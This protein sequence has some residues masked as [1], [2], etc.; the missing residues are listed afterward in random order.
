MTATVQP[1]ERGLFGRIDGVF[2]RLIKGW[3]PYHPD[4]LQDRDLELVDVQES[5]VRKRGTSLIMIAVAA[6]LLWAFTAPIN[7]GSS[8][9]GTVTVA[10]YRKAVQHPSGGVVSRVLVSEGEQVRQGQVL[11]RIN[12]LETEATVA[13]L[14]QEYINLLVSESRAKA[15]LLGRPISWDPDL[16]KLNPVRVAE[17]KAIQMSLYQNRRTQFAEQVRGLNSQIGG[18]SGAISA[19]RVQL[20]TLSE[21]LSSVEDLSRQGFVPKSQVNTTLRSKVDQEAALQTAESEVG[22]TRAQIAQTRSQF[23]S[24]VA[25]ELAEMQ[26]NRQSVVTK[27]QAARFAQSLSE[28]RAPV[29]GTIVNLKVFTEGGVISGG[30]LLMEIVPK[31]GVLIVEAKVPPSAIDT[32]RVGQEADVRFSSFNATTTPIIVGVVKSVGVDKL[33]AE[34]G[35]EVREGEDYY[36]AQIETS[37]A[38]LRALGDLQLRPGMPADVIVKSGERTFMSYLFKPMLDKFARAFKD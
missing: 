2:D 4:K 10:G 21:E 12:P 1:E 9:A 14:E 34:P 24:E 23:Q 29:G 7:A 19:H 22:K 30:Q 37:A 25:T 8:M 36:L 5:T 13:N 38:A 27:L 11:L 6:F 16:A 15:E 33:K 18:L 20:N 28:I 32:V 31:Q 26:K 3:N 35:A 17:A